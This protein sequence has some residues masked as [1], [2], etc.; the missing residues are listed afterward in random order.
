[1][2]LRTVSPSLLV[3][4]LFLPPVLRAE[5]TQEQALFNAPAPHVAAGGQMIAV[6]RTRLHGY[7]GDEEGN[8]KSLAFLK[9]SVQQCV[10]TYQKS[11]KPSNPPKAWPTYVSAARED[12]YMAANRIVRYTGGV[13][14]VV[15]PADC[16]LMT[17]MVE[18]ASL[19]SSLGACNI[20]ITHK[21]AEGFCDASGHAKAA[22]EKLPAA[23]SQAGQAGN[24]AMLQ[25]MAADPKTAAM[26]AALMK[27][28]KQS[29]QTGASKFIL[30]I[31]CEVHSFPGG[32]TV[33]L[34][35]GGS[36][37][38]ARLAGN[39]GYAGLLLEMRATTGY[40]MTA[41]DA[42]LDDKVASGVFTPYL[43]SGYTVDNQGPLQ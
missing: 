13:T 15:N 39:A 42:K 18:N 8:A 30:G 1:M 25:K 26:A 40:T 5:T 33:C 23:P 9:Q 7:L 6:H 27:T 37:T 22:A 2:T 29:A 32:G 10:A 19:T 28:M 17:E 3:V 41:V 4:L 11:G 38:P 24:L 34:A 14:Y 12:T 35:P 21:R 31:S 36:F 43:G 20:D 16:S